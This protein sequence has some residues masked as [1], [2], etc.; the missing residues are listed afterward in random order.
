MSVCWLCV[1]ALGASALVAGRS[2]AAQQ[3]APDTRRIIGEVLDSAARPVQGVR[4]S[5]IGLDRETES[6]ARGR[7]E[8]RDLPAARMRVLTRRLGFAPETL[9][10]STE[11]P[12]PAIVQLMLGRAVGQLSP[13]VVSAAADADP[14]MV[15]FYERA[16]LGRG[17]FL[18]AADI[19]RRGY[20]RM[21]DI[22][23]AVPGMMTLPRPNSRTGARMRAT[24]QAP[25]V[26]LDGTPLGSS[27][28]D[29]D[30]FDPRAYAGVEIYSGP[31][32]V[33]A[34]F[35][36][37]TLMSSSG[38][39]I[40]LWT[41]RGQV[42]PRRVRQPREASARLIHDLVARGEAFGPEDVDEPARQADAGAAIKPEYPDSLLR[43]GVGGSALVEFIVDSTGAVRLDTFGVIAT[44]H[45]LF[46]DPVRSAVAAH[47][48]IPAQL[49][50]RPVAQVVML[51]F[52]FVPDSSVVLPRTRPPR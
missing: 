45:P 46:A 24:R 32:T 26:W 14:R 44:S 36:G 21:T 16:R 20:T 8:L 30:S 7:F 5:V 49:A 10:V 50:G 6:D 25:L 39:V 43:N 15:A 17:R 37:N 1:L 51:P 38:G 27:E 18:T 41:K 40:V 28:F 3:A 29:L 47:R 9:S 42:T 52:V 34:E 35:A 33:P 31:A 12:E 23:R 11:L 48:Y 19:E 2:V 13:V 4:V 22:L